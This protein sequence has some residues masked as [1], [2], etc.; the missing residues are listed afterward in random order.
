MMFTFRGTRVVTESGQ[1]W[2]EAAEVAL[3]ATM[4]ATKNKHE[5][6]GHS[7]SN[8]SASCPIGHN[9]RQ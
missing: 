4:A 7:N 6:N 3:A 5:S 8:R 1:H 9:Q 2:T